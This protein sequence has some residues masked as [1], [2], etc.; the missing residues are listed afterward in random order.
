MLK[1]TNNIPDIIA[2]K[3]NDVYLQVICPKDLGIE[4]EIS[5]YFRFQVPN[6]KFM[7]AYK[8]GNWDGYIYLYDK[9]RS[10][11][12]YVGLWGYLKNWASERGYLIELIDTCEGEIST[13]NENYGNSGKLID[14]LPSLE[15]YSN[16][17]SIQPHEYQIAAFVH[18]IEN[19][20][21]ILLSPTASGKSLIIYSICRYLL[22]NQKKKILIIV[23]TTGLVEQMAKDFLDYSSEDVSWDGTEYIH[24]IYSGKEKISPKRLTISTWQSIYKQPK[25]YF[26]DY[27]VVLC[28]EVHTAQAKSITD[29][30]TKMEKCPWRIGTTGT[31]Q[32]SKMHKLMLEGLFGSVYTVT[33]TRKL[34]DDKHISDLKISCLMLQYPEE[35]CKAIKK[36]S[37]KEEIDFL[38]THKKRNNFIVNLV[39]SLKGNT[40][41]S[42]HITEH[43]KYLKKL[44][45][46]KTAESKRKVFLIYGKTEV[47]TREEI[48]SI[49]EKEKDAI[50]IASRGT[51]SV[52]VNI[53][54]L[55]NLVFTH[56]LKAPI[57]NR[58]SIGRTLRLGD[59][60]IVANLY[61]IVDVLKYK[62]HFNYVLKH[63]L[64]HRLNIYNDEEFFYQTHN[65][66]F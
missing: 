15:P 29:I 17:K 24:K 31:I 14:Y 38:I 2:T 10:K 5:D 60:K 49:T 19:K 48:R 4:Q 28:D 16:G 3:L 43:G 65:I 42:F 39:L 34:I 25:K 57:G 33:T 6:Y 61:D 26:E 30:L 55:H 51:S 18:A 52:G 58:Q 13:K 27:G 66:P 62:S 22:D 9:V 50:I 41:V 59:D 21:S 11:R 63:F 44:F 37:Y 53:R 7:P 8:N 45:D 40:M 23:P 56:P 12:L 64:N 47:D 20:R 32:D 46:A 1:N 35:V 36:F 54:N